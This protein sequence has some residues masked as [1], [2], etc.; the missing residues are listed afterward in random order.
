MVMAMLQILLG[1]SPKP[2]TFSLTQRF[3]SL[4]SINII[5]IIIIILI[6]DL[7]QHQESEPEAHK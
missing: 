7:S 1:L 3:L 5:I 2:E 6:I 4:A